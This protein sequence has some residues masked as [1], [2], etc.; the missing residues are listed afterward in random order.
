[1]VVEK[2]RAYIDGAD[3]SPHPCTARKAKGERWKAT[4]I[5]MSSALTHDKKPG[6]ALGTQSRRERKEKWH[7]RLSGQLIDD[8]T[9]AD[10][11]I[12]QF[13]AGKQ[14]LKV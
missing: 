5:M 6:D 13:S 14:P 12:E 1:M 11:I 2:T 10:V 9:R 8:L 4:E 3:T 7:G